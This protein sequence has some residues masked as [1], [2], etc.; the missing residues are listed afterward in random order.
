MLRLLSE[1]LYLGF[2]CVCLFW[3]MHVP[4]STTLNIVRAHTSLRSLEH[5]NVHLVPARISSL[6]HPPLNIKLFQFSN[7]LVTEWSYG[8]WSNCSKPCGFST[9]FRL[10][11]C[12]KNCAKFGNRTT[13]EKEL[14]LCN[15]NECG[16][17]GM[18]NLLLCI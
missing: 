10:N 1:S 9:K 3:C 13:V 12:I 7:F 8:T 17:Y 4:A 18:Y 2:I 14:A 5:A 11:T 6:F 15:V 16:N